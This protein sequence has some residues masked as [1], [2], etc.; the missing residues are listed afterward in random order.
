MKKWRKLEDYKKVKEHIIKKM[1]IEEKIKDINI[2]I[3]VRTTK[4]QDRM[5]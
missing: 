5:G 3:I 2:K 4:I 1:K